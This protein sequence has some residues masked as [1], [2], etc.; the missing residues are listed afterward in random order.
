V[1]EASPFPYAETQVSGGGLDGVQGGNL[2]A[3]EQSRAREAAAFEQGRQ[4]AHQQVR[5]ELDA[6]LNENRRQITAFLQQFAAERQNYYR[7][8]EGEI[9][10]L[11]LAIARKILYREAQ[12]DPRALAGIVRVTLEKLDAGTAVNLHVSPKEAAD[13][14]HYFAC[15]MEGLPVPEVHEDPTVP[16]GECRIE[17][18]LGATEV[19]FQSQLKEI[20]TGLLDLLAERPEAGSLPSS[21]PLPDRSGAE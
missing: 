9:V 21:K 4:A 20:E 10:Q 14:R 8:V 18:S 1:P 19:G 6:A 7:R 2:T 11:A 12:L 16:A 5:T 13:W 3:E 15:Q 17:T